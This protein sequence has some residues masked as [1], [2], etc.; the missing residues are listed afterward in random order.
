MSAG[1]SMAPDG[2]AARHWRATV[3]ARAAQMDAAYAR[4][5]RTSADFWDRRARTFHRATRDGTTDPFYH[6]VAPHVGRRT[7]VLDVGAG[8]GRFALALAARAADVLAVE[9]NLSMLTI[10]REEAARQGVANLRTLQRRWEECDELSADVV[11][12]SHVLYPLAE[13]APF[14]ARLDRA[15]RRRC[16]VSLRAIHLDE[17]TDPLWRHFHG[18]PR[19]L[20]PTY[21]DGV[22][23]LHEL[24]IL[25]EV[26]IVH[27]RQS[28]RFPDLASAADEILEHL[29][30]ADHAE[31]RAELID[32]LRE[33]LA[34]TPEG[35]LRL[36]LDTM[37]VG[38]LSWGPEQR[39]APII[40][41]GSTR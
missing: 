12:A 8:T 27:S 35:G 14:L 24:G 11:L 32:L 40:S 4:L 16:F 30:L 10:L 22:N 2:P 33:W 31:T 25:A 13:A 20:P 9:P 36:P 7:S 19:R 17:L 38:V 15:T 29:I 3:Q 34:T 1:Y 26:R 41:G 28:W 5:G 21:L 6:L 23:L 18:E 37:P 39:Y